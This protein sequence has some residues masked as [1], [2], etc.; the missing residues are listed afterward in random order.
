MDEN[1][2]VG[3]YYYMLLFIIFYKLIKFFLNIIGHVVTYELIQLA[4]QG[5]NKTYFT[6]FILEDEK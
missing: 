3:N 6:N 5:E 2:L 1:E 4:M